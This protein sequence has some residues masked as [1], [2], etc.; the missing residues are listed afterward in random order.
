MNRLGVF[1]VAIFIRPLN[2]LIFVLVLV[3]LFTTGFHSR[4]GQPCSN[5]Y[6]ELLHDQKP[7]I[8]SIEYQITRCRGSRADKTKI[9]EYLSK[10][11]NARAIDNKRREQAMATLE[12]K[13]IYPSRAGAAAYNE[14]L[15]EE[16]VKLNRADWMPAP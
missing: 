9:Q 7:I 3:S 13:G 1:I 12:A 11:A 5:L 10:L 14:A 6:H 16:I 8:A 4:F 2:W 15:E